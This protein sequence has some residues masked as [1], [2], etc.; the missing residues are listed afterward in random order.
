MQPVSLLFCITERPAPAGTVAASPIHRQHFFAKFKQC[1]GATLSFALNCQ[2]GE[3]LLLPLPS[4]RSL[5]S[6]T[7]SAR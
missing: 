6:L 1:S 3:V 2:K 7:F 5:A 4:R